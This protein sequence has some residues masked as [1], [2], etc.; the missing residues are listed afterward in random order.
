MILEQTTDNNLMKRIMTD[1]EMWEKIGVI[2]VDIDHFSPVISKNMLVLSAIVGNV[3]GLHLFIQKPEGV[4]FHP[5]LLKEFRKEF[6]REFMKKGIDWIFNKTATEFIF[7][8][9]PSSHTSTI[10][11]A[12]HLNFKEVQNNGNLQR[13]R[14]EK[15]DLWAA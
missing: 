9:I 12:K 5:M 15:G 3:I 11:L 13:L 2:E 10:N 1:P 14:L 7:A 4:F 6:G 8:E